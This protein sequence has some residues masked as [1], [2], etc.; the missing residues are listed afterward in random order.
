M[1]LPI[2]VR[3]VWRNQRAQ[4]QHSS[5]HRSNPTTTHKP[6]FITTQR[7]L[8]QKNPSHSQP[9]WQTWGLPENA[10]SLPD[11]TPRCGGCSLGHFHPLV[12]HPC[13]TSASPSSALQSAHP[14]EDSVTAGGMATCWQCGVQLRCSGDA[15]PRDCA[16]VF[17]IPA[18]DQPNA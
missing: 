17:P 1:I 4:T 11:K 15:V 14:A 5:G 13:H 8:V 3:L 7:V 18:A 2:A 10:A 16:R 9:A 12:H 6:H